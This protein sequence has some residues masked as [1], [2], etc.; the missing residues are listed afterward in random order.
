[1]SGQGENAGAVLVTGSRGFIGRTLVRRLLERGRR[2]VEFD[3]EADEEP[4]STRLVVGNLEDA[5]RLHAALRL[6][7]VSEVVHL[8]G[9]S[10]P[11]LAR[12]DPH[13][14]MRINVGGT[15]NVL[16]AARLAGVRRVV[17]LSS[18]MAYG[19]QPDDRVIGEER[20]LN[21]ADAYGASKIAGE[22]MMRAYAAEHGMDAVSLRVSSVFGPERRTDCSINTMLRQ[23]LAGK[24]VRIG[25]GRNARRQYVHVDDVAE[26][27]L[28]VLSLPR[29]P[30]PAY[31]VTGGTCVSLGT[32]A[33]IVESILPQAEIRLEDAAHPFDYPIGPLDVSAARRDFG[34]VPGLTLEGGIR[35]HLEE[36]VARQERE[37]ENGARASER[38]AATR[39]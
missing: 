7:A 2:V 35:R 30:L 22:A 17:F 9:L 3:R 10:G 8:G 18:I 23:T 6:D 4:A 12:D 32:V 39:G 38:D 1:M 37:A 20:P 28:S 5:H 29:L 24:P 31:N 27:I 36:L 13:R 11:M 26:A 34:Y 33:G 19:P 21:A 25:Y 16:E 14:M 15:A